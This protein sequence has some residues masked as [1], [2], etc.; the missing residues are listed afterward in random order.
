MAGT[1]TT[2]P[3]PSAFLRSHIPPQNIAA[4]SYNQATI[5]VAV[6]GRHVVTAAGRLEG[7]AYNVGTCGSGGNSVFRFRRI[8]A[9]SSTPAD[10]GA[11]AITVA[12]TEVDGFVGIAPIG[13]DVDVGDV[14]ECNVTT[15][16]TAGANLCWAPIISRLMTP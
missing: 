13:I 10:L 4:P 1:P 14:I 12:N 15:A 2:T 11:A 5:A 9:R 16:P 3:S 7:I 8:P 6:F